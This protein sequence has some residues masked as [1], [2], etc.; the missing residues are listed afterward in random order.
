VYT[1][2]KIYNLA[3]QSLL[4]ARNIINTDTDASNEAKVLNTHWDVVLK[5]VL[6]DL[7]LDSTASQT[8][9]ALIHDFTNDPPPT[10]GEVGPIWKYAYKY[11]SNCAY[12]RRIVSCNVID[13]KFTHHPKRVLIYNNAGTPVKTIFCNVPSAIGEYIPNDFPLQTLSAPAGQALAQFL[14]WWSAPLIVGKGAKTLRDSI[15]KDYAAIKAM[16]QALD[17]R[18]SFSFQSDE[19]MSEFVKTRLS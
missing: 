13:D 18:E 17:E 7:D 2:A 6:F 8:N 12:F 5:T 1:K 16:A 10:T 11:P 19:N 14:A 9:L 3:L 15:L 4:L